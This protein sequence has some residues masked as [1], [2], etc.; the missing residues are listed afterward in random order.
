MKLYLLRHEKRSLRDPTFHSPLLQ[1]GLRDAEK[2][3]Y[4]LDDLNINLIFHLFSNLKNIFFPITSEL[5]LRKG[6]NN[7]GYAILEKLIVFIFS[8]F[9]I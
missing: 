8:I 5:L 2:L 4:L 7:N 6:K 9:S 1:N 3:K